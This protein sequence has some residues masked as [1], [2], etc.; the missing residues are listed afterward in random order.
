MA[1]GVRASHQPDAPSGLPKKAP[2]ERGKTR[3]AD[4]VRRKQSLAQPQAAHRV[5]SVVLKKVDMPPVFPHLD[6][7]APKNAAGSARVP[8]RVTHWNNWA[9]GRRLNRPKMT[10]QDH[11]HFS[12]ESALR[13]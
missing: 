11:I 10:C 2:A 6:A 4:Q 12:R 7:C 3:T 9:N 5:K 8:I 13:V 1:E